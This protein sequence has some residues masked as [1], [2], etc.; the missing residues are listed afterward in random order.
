MVGVDEGLMK[1]LDSVRGW[2]KIPIVITS[3]L[4]T[5][6]H[7]KEVGGTGDGPHTRGLAVDLRCRNSRERFLI[8]KAA[9]MSGFLRIGDEV[10]HVH[11]D[12][13]PEGDVQVL[14]RK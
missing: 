8:I 7:D 3:G 1:M 14:W 6:E 10:D 2:A 5:P 13:D 12:I 11:L 4:R 9:I